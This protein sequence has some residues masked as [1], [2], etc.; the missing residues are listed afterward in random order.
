[1]QLQAVSDPSYLFEY[2]FAQIDRL[3]TKLELSRSRRYQSSAIKFSNYH[4]LR[5]NENNATQQTLV[6]EGAIERRLNLYRIKGEIGLEANFLKSYR[7]SDLNTDGPDSD[8]LVDGYD[9]TRVSL[10][11]NW[12]HGWETKNGIILDFENEFGL[13]QYDVQQH[14]AIGPEATQIFGAGAVGLRWPWYHINPTGGI[15]IV[16]P[17]IQLVRSV[18]SNST[19]PNDDSTQIEFDE[20]NLFRLNRA[21]GLDLIEHGTRLNVGLAGSQFKDSGSSLSW[22]IGRIFRSQA[23]PTFPS[24]SGLSNIMSDWLV[25]TS[26][27]QKNGIELINRA[28][29]ASDGAVTK[30]ETSLK[31]DSGL[32]QIRATH[33]ELTKDSNSYQNKSLSSVG[34]EWNYNLTSNWQSDAKFQFDSNI[35]RLSK[36]ELGLNYENECVNVDLSTSRSFSISST[37]LDKTDFTLSVELTGFSSSDRKNAKSHKCGVQ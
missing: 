33:V 6:A 20:G 12:N 35:G 2:D 21:P 24:G 11:S 27:Q 14:A 31:L 9:T 19:V 26:F 28:L 18:S 17:Q 30:S 1:M 25:A 32:H 37:L 7:Y 10:L 15:G 5:E 23:L 29:I 16:E 34:L 13:S 8:T 3:N 36:L 4:S 22:K